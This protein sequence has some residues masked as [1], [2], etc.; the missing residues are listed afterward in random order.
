MKPLSLVVLISGSGSNLQAIIDA[1]E[2]GMLNAQI[3]AVISNRPDAYGLTRAREHG[4]PAISLDHTQFSDREHFDRQLQQQIDDLH[5]D[6]IVL[7]GYMRILST[8]FIQHFHPH[9]LNVHPSLLPRY[10][11][12]RTHQRALDNGD[13]EHGVS[14]HI[15]TPELDSGPVILQGR[16]AIDPSDTADSLQQ[17]AHRLEHRMYPQVLQWFSEGRLSLED[18]Q[19]WFDHQPLQQPIEFQA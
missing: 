16:F 10:Q 12:L 9:I 17:K 2:A 6:L 1:I 11:G 3:R 19:P 18:G 5:P 15:V 7:A 13:R 14:I 4:I 8:A